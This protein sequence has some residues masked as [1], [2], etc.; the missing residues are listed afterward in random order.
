MSALGCKCG[1]RIADQTDFLPYK[2]RILK[3]EDQEKCW[4]TI[5]T[6]IATFV[7]AV[8]TNKREEWLDRHFGRDY[9]R[10][11]SDESIISLW[12][13]S[14]HNRYMVTIYECENCGRLYLQKGTDSNIFFSYFPDDSKRH[15]I[16]GSEFNK[17]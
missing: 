12:L 5:Y 11:L 9:P 3:D 13:I 8:V 2:G 10:G 14:V 16:L 17:R 6:E 1:H 4:S 15:H 7:E